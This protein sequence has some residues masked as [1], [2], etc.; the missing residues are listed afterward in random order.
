MPGVIAFIAG[1][2]RAVAALAAVLV[3]AGYIETLRIE[4]EHAYAAEA[5]AKAALATF[6]TEVAALGKRAEL[7][8]A[9]HEAADKKR[10]D[11]ADAE[12]SA[13]LATLAGTIA[14]LRAR[15]GG[16]RVPAA[17]AGSSRPD[18]A[19]FDRPESERAY[20]ALVAG[21]RGLADEGA[22]SAVELNTAKAWA[23][24]R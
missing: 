23:Q 6:K 9:A 19:C 21:L 13:A 4:R 3:L 1:H 17:P 18:L 16:G 7:D 24:G 5:T 22:K 10:K 2:W 12:N 20:G 15:P 8:K 14:K 11:D